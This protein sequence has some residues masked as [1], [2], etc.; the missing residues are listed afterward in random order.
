MVFTCPKCFLPIR[1]FG[2]HLRQN[3]K[4]SS[5]SASAVVP[6]TEPQLDI[7]F[8]YDIMAAERRRRLTDVLSE[9]RYEKCKSNTDVAHIKLWFGEMYDAANLKA[10]DALQPLLQSG[11]TGDDVQRALTGVGSSAFAGI[12]TRERELAHA[13]TNVPYLEPRVVSL[14]PEKSLNDQVVSF[15]QKDLLIRDLQHDPVVRKHTLKKSDEWKTGETWCATRAARR[16]RQPRQ[17]TAP[18]CPLPPSI[19]LRVRP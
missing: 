13:K 11:V 4:C 12:E 17:A 8:Q 5:R 19:R 3:P 7:R 15:S 1:S 18:P 9:C 16:P 14:T 10:Y 6:K 2:Q